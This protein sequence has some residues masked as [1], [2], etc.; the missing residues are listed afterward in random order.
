MI[1]HPAAR[2]ETAHLNETLEIVAQQQL[3]SAEELTVAKKNLQDTFRFERDNMDLL[4]VRQIMFDR[5]EQAVR[6]MAAA[7][8]RPYFTRVNFTEESGVKQVYYIGKHSVFRPNSVEPAVIDWRSPIANLYYSGQVGKMHYVAPDGEVRGELTLKRQFGIENGE[9]ISIFDTDVVSKDAYLQSVLGAT[10][11]ERLRD[12][13][14]SIQA[15]QNIV[16]RHPANVTLVVQGV[17]GSGKTTIALHRIA[18]LLYTLQDSLR[19][20]HVLILAPN[21]LFL[22]FIA[23][24]LPDLGVEKV[25]QTTFPLLVSGWL[26]KLLPRVNTADQTDR[27]LALPPD[28]REDFIDMMHYKGSLEF[29]RRL[30]QWLDGFEERLPPQDAL[31]FGPFTL[32]TP[33]QTRAFLVEGEKPFPFAVRIERFKKELTQRAKEAAGKVNA[34]LEAETQRRADALHALPDSPQRR[35]RLFKLYQSRDQRLKETNE[36]VR[37]FVDEVMK[38]FPALRPIELYRA[39]L[40]DLLSE[41]DP[42]SPVCAAAEYTLKRVGSRVEP[43]DVAPIALIA[44]RAHPLERMDIRHIVIDEAQDFSPAEFLLLRRMTHNAPMTVVGDLMQGIRSWRGLTDW[45]TLT[46]DL[47]GGKAVTHALVTSYRNTVEIMNT[48]LRVALKRPV[49]GQT[50]VKPVLRHGP[51][52]EIIAFSKPAEQTAQIERLIRAWQSDNVKTIAVIDR[53]DAQL[54][55]LLKALPADLNARILDVN[56]ELYEGGVLLARAGDIKGFEFDG[57]IIANASEARFPNTE[58][59][60]RLLYVCLTRPLHRLACLYEKTLTPLLAE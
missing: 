48:A 50:E 17:A 26:G 33:E 44:L 22:N 37:P 54:K 3:I 27:L 32:F 16:I 6:N 59:D 39:F 7:R 9:L 28:E 21:P 14:T 15:E 10:T 18:Y 35:E 57:V 4:G 13:V 40:T 60:A 43:E 25:R 5:S 29:T 24:V 46:D 12:I 49:P 58:L 47:L 31:K 55:A 2:E 30:D 38:A 36:R 56:G 11:G 34:W 45:R 20:E 1:D 51:E 52:P 41:S 23:G 42:D 19:P 8:L 53:T